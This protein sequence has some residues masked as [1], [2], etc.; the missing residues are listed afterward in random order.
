[1]YCQLGLIVNTWL[2][3]ITGGMVWNPCAGTC[4]IT[5][6][7]LQ[8]KITVTTYSTVMAHIILYHI[9][10]SDITRISPKV[11][12]SYLS[13]VI[14]IIFNIIYMAYRHIPTMTDSHHGGFLSV[15]IMVRICQVKKS[16]HL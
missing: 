9:C 15:M 11:S 4:T 6:A 16:H 12:P 8:E 5:I 14:I 7:T 2:F 10:D 13:S 3:L 1:M